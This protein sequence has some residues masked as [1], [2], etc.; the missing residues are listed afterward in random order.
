MPENNFDFE[1]VLHI[2][3]Q[4]NIYSVIGK[5]ETLLEFFKSNPKYKSLCPFLETYLLITKS[6]AEKYSLKKS[7]FQ[8]LPQLQNLD[9]Y[10][11]KLY[12]QPLLKYL[13]TKEKTKPWKT[14]F[15]YCELENGIPLIQLMLGIN[16]H[17]NTDLFMSLKKI[18]YKSEKDFFQVNNILL[19]S[20]PKVMKML[21]SKHDPVGFGGIIFKDFIEKE[22]HIIIES[23]RSNAWANYKLKSEENL[24]TENTEKMGKEIIN[25]I[26]N[27]YN[28]HKPLGIFHLNHISI[29][30]IS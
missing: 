14:Y 1:K 17:I 10:F 6:V 27:I 15:E 28:L 9:I 25:I 22:F 24:I 21:I 12:F 19:D 2:S 26:T 23:W 5:M 3:S 16:S 11:A 18:N 29:N 13:K 20:I 8:N 4:E 7:I 30:K